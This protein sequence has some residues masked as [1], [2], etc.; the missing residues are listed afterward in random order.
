MISVSKLFTDNLL[1][2]NPSVEFDPGEAPGG[3]KRI[4]VISRSKK[5]SFPPQSDDHDEKEVR[6]ITPDEEVIKKDAIVR[7]PVSGEK[8]AVD[9]P[10]VIIRRK[11]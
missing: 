10:P 4:L 9:E 11:R 8:V 7:D 2:V 1:N 3:K 5:I 6:D